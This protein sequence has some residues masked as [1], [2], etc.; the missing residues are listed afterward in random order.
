MIVSHQTDGRE[1]LWG[2]L[3][4]ERGTINSIVV[5]EQMGETGTNSTRW[6]QYNWHCWVLLLVVAVTK[7]VDD[8]DANA[9]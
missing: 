2:V 6:W 8:D 5:A 3:F 4:V 7:C 1:W 9:A